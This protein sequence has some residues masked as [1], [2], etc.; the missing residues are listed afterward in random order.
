MTSW[1]L[2]EITH[3]TQALHGVKFRGRLRLFGLRNNTDLL[4]ENATDKENCVRFAVHA[5][6]NTNSIVDMIQKAA[7]GSDVKIVMNDVSNPVLSK[8]IVN[9]HERYEHEF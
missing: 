9:K 2:Y 7:S 6:T 4:C 5:G 3:S 1:D 8:I